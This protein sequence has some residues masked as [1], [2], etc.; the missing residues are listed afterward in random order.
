MERQPQPCRVRTRGTQQFDGIVEG[1][2]ELSREIVGGTATRQRQAH[3]Q[4]AI[5]VA[6]RRFGKDLRQF[7][8]A[9]EDEVAHALACP[10]LAD[11][12]ARLDRMHE[13]DMRVGEHRADQRHLGSRG[14]VEMAHAAL[15]DG[16]QHGRLRVAFH[17]VQ[18]VAGEA[19]DKGAGG[20]DDGSSGAAR[21]SAPP[22][23]PR[24]PDRQRRAATSRRTRMSGAA[25]TR[26]R[27]REAGSWQNPRSNDR[28]RAWRRSAGRRTG[29]RARR[30]ARHSTGDARTSHCAGPFNQHRRHPHDPGPLSAGSIEKDAVRRC[31]APHQGGLAARAMRQGAATGSVAGARI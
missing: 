2:A 19:A 15:V 4:P 31:C 24:R 1:G 17:G 29:K 26:R 22:A 3:D 27:G 12:A 9:V 13:S 20:G 7:F 6:A 25:E 21:A 11:G 18:H 30:G 14:A 16:A 23:A 8:G 28:P 5:R 10:C